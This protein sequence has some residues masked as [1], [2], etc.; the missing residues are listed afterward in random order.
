MNEKIVYHASKTHGLIT[1]QPKEST[2]RQKWLYATKNIATSAMFL[3]KN[4]DFICQ[5]GTEN[6]KPYVYEQ[7]KGALEHAYTGQTGS[8]YKLDGKNFKSG[9]TSWSAEVVSETAVSVLEEINIKDSLKFLFDLQ[10]ED[11]LKIYRYPNRPKNA[12]KD[13][14]DIINKAAQWT[15]DLG[16]NVLEQVKKYHP[17]ILPKVLKKIEEIK[18]ISK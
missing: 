3:G 13:K 8:I 5:T 4:F 2:H 7:F 12:P 17:D 9:R 10:K 15:I 11:K 6:G 18:K 16:E 1:L 14:S